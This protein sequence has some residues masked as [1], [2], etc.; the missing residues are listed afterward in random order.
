MIRQVPGA[1]GAFLSA[2]TPEWHFHVSMLLILEAHE[3]ERSS[4]DAV[5]ETLTNRIHR[6]PQF[7]WKLQAAPVTTIA[8]PYWVDDDMFDLDRHLSHVALPQPGDDLALARLVGR[9][10]SSRLDRTRPLWEMWVIDGLDG[11]RSALL[12]KVHHAIIDG[13]SGAEL[14]TVLFDLERDPEPDSQ[15]P[16][17]HPEPA[18][19]GTVM[20]GDIAHRATGWPYRVAQL[21]RQFVRQ[22]A[23]YLRHTIGPAPITHPFQAPRTPFNGT[24]TPSRSFAAASISLADAKV[25]KDAFGVK[26]N[27]VVL[28]VVSGVLR[29][30]LADLDELPDQPLVAQIPVSMR[31]DADAH[32]GTKVSMMFSA[33]ATDVDDPADRLR[34]IHATTSASKEM[35]QALTADQI[36]SLT[37]NTAPAL[38]AMAALAW[39]AGG[40]DSAAPPVFNVIVSNVPGPPLDLY[41]AGARI[42]AMYPMGPL[43]FGAG[44][45]FTIV[46]N[47][48]RLDIG[49]LACPDLLPDVWSVAD[50]VGPA[51]DEL[52]DAANAPR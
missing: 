3:S 5:R 24:L 49:I 23:T 25:V 16:A 45:N 36:M 8:R 28:A 40:L 52:V 41:L 7:R 48:T 30:Y 18:P 44:L 1:D 10:L 22:G 38:V 50:R 21:G 33:I 39:T 4:F 43:L 32:V 15:P 35:R 19:S 17:W 47:A 2:E 29:S 9:L 31:A 20:L 11:G 37:D 34:S 27:D 42:A 14:A 12:A 6:V 51:F 26:L 13:Q 46:S